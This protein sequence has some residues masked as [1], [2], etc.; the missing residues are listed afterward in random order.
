MELG[1]GLDRIE[2]NGMSLVAICPIC[3][4]FLFFFFVAIWVDLILPFW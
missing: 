4:V 1:F 2:W 3:G